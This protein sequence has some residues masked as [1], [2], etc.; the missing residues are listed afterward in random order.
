MPKVVLFETISRVFIRDH[1]DGFQVYFENVQ[2]VFTHENTDGFVCNC[3]KVNC[4]YSGFNIA[5]R[6][7]VHM[8]GPSQNCDLANA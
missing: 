4:V 1:P 2:R 6:M 5:N 7:N 8:Q 3:G